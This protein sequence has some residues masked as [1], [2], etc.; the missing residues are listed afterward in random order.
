M[1]GPNQRRTS[2]CT[3]LLDTDPGSCLVHED[4]TDDGITAARTAGMDVI[5][6]R[7]R[8]WR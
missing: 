2:T 6:I 1:G 4:D 3:R 7:H 5:D 8:A